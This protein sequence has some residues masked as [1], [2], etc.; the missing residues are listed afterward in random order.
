MD[1]NIRLDIY[2]IMLYIVYIG[3]FTKVTRGSVMIV[4][5]LQVYNF[6]I[7]KSADEKPNALAGE[8][9]T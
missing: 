8:N 4:S 6:R 5:Q 9:F 1:L 7:F 2:L 3:N